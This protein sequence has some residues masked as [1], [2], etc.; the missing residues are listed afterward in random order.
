MFENGLRI[1]EV[2]GLT[3]ED[4]VVEKIGD[5]YIT[6]ANIRNRFSDKN[7]Q[8]AKT[9]M[10]IISRSQYES[11][12]YAISGFG[13]QKVVLSDELFQLIDE[14]IENFHIKAREE[15]SINYWKNSVAD[16]VVSNSIVDDNY[17]IFINSI[18]NPLHSHLWNTTLRKIFKS[19]GIA[20]DENTRIHNLNHRF[21]HGYAMFC[22]QHLNLNQLELM[23][24][25]R[26]SSIESVALYYKPTLTDSINLKNS[27]TK[28]MYELIPSLGRG[29]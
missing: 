28:S 22:I 6:I 26:H 4:L 16:K 24:R 13:F 18:G 8:K 10:K 3:A 2:L 25:M 23:E 15:Y 29:R 27:F 19:V 12:D 14:Y 5:N 1:G 21:R 9:C 20:V 17:Y 11:S 7:D